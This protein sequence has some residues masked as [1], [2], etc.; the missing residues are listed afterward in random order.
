MGS[1]TEQFIGDGNPVNL[2]TRRH[3]HQADELS[4]S[5]QHVLGSDLRRINKMK[6]RRG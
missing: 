5:V 4:Q 2:H 6:T 1:Y 3:V